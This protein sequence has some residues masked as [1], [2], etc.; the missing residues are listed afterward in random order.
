MAVF[1]PPHPTHPTPLCWHL[2]LHLG[3][4]LW[5]HSGER[6]AQPLRLHLAICQRLLGTRGSAGIAGKPDRGPR[7]LGF[8][9]KEAPLSAHT[10]SAS[11]PGE[12]GVGMGGGGCKASALTHQEVVTVGKGKQ[13]PTDHPGRC[14]SACERRAVRFN[15]DVLISARRPENKQR[16]SGGSP[17]Y[18]NTAG[19]R[20]KS[21]GLPSRQRV[22]KISRTDEGVAVKATG[23][24]PVAAAWRC[25]VPMKIATRRSSSS[26]RHANY[27]QAHRAVIE[28]NPALFQE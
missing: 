8:R 2:A 3:P 1:H 25:S 20:W 7:L 6:L 13:S 26:Q 17:P 21:A 15:W 27:R 16:V 23:F 24:T 11:G 5:F 18:P 14:R 4:V 19:K 12:L 22:P 10:R 9:V 28:P